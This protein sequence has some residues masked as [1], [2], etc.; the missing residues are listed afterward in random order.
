MTSTKLARSTRTTWPAFDDLADAPH[1]PLRGVKVLDLSALLPGPVATRSLADMGAEVL[2]VE[3]VGDG[4]PLR[5][6]MPDSFQAV[7]R[8]KRSMSLD[9]KTPE[10]QDVVQQLAAQADVF[11][12]GFRPGV[13]DRL[14]CSAL[15]LLELNPR[16]VYC[17]ISGYGQHSLRRDEPGHDV[18]YLA[19]AGALAPHLSQGE[20]SAVL[21]A[22]DMLAA[23]QATTAICA[24]LLR[25]K[26]GGSGTHIDL[27]M[28]DCA[29]AAMS[30][31]INEQ[32]QSDSPKDG[33]HPAYGVFT[34]GDG[35]RIAVG[36]TENEFFERLCRELSLNDLLTVGFEDYQTRQRSWRLIEDRIAQVIATRDGAHWI[37]TLK[38]A[39]VPVTPVHT[40][41]SVR[42]DP[43]L[44]ARGVM[45]IEGDTV[46][47]PFPALFDG[48][49]PR[50]RYA[51]PAL[52]E[53]NE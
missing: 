53:A 41:A 36:C 39:G 1:L 6:L 45:V 17:S 38:S 42:T 26:S 11:V 30:H 15:R 22:A 50:Y 10:A 8:N 16:L 4:D 20:P 7:N 31:L 12:E 9:L 35:A 3:R 44:V 28:T 5:V 48:H 34:A 18:N 47:V 25:V 14:G 33:R 2:K 43:D 40:L 52:G 19:L 24:A 27:S 32:V 46:Q 37:D 13:T 23:A 29:V 51:A 21:P 49:R